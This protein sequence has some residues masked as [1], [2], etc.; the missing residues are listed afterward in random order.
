MRE[1]INKKQT[2]E[3][4]SVTETERDLRL[5]EVCLCLSLLESRGWKVVENP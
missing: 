4:S 1:R 2:I 5:R 3:L